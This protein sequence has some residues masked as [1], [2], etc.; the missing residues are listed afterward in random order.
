MSEEKTVE[1]LTQELE[2]ALKAEA[3]AKELVEQLQEENANLKAEV[4]RLLETPDDKETDNG[5]GQCFEYDG[6]KYKI[7][8][9]AI[10]IPKLGKRTALEIL[11]DTEAQAWL[12]TKGSES[13]K[14]VH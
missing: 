3:D 13:V 14:K 9:P 7:L 1:Q 4:E 6:S 10:R 2:A 11:N 12:V 5:V 8:V